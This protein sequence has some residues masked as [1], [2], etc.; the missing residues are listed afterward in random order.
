MQK[1]FA[2]RFYGSEMYAMDE[3]EAS[4]AL[5]GRFAAST[6]KARVRQP[7]SDE[8]DS[9]PYDLNS[10]CALSAPATRLN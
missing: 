3:V 1:M 9:H 6:A 5:V 2:I 8:L 7:D 10:S 4:P